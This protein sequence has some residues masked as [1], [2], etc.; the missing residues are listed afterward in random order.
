M[1]FDFAARGT[2]VIIWDINGDAIK[3][4]EDEGR[5]IFFYLRH[6]LRRI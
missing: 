4:A 3:A 5:Q 1:A 6:D 2:K